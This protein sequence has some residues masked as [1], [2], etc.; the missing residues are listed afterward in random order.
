MKSGILA[1]VILLS[2]GVLASEPQLNL[3]CEDRATFL[4][5]PPHLGN[6]VADYTKVIVQVQN[7]ASFG[8]AQLINLVN[9]LDASVKK[10]DL[11]YVVFEIAREQCR[12]ANL[13]VSVE[14]FNSGRVF[15]SVMCSSIINKLNPAQITVVLKDGTERT[16]ESLVDIS[17]YIKGTMSAWTGNTSLD[18]Y[19]TIRI[20]DPKETWRDLAAIEVLGGG[21]RVCN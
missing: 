14:G 3:R 17:L 21:G 18:Q 4:P 12:T 2:Q 20:L 7:V 13:K 16:H 19:L 1:L 11:K 6:I 10:E 8:K 15:P 9:V 5:Q